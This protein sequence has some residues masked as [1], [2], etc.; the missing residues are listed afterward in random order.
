[1]IASASESHIPA[2]SRVT[3]VSVPSKP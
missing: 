1:M 3:A 2:G